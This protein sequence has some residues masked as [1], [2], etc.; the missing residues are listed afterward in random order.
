MGRTLKTIPKVF[1]ADNFW[2]RLMGLMGRK[3]WPRHW[4]AICFPRCNAVHTFFV[5]LKF[6]ILFLDSEKK[7]L[8]IVLNAKSWWFY[9]GPLSGEYCLELPSDFIRKNKLKPGDK[10]DW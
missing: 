7:I 8:K 2:P 5:F 10:V 4:G 3:N 1:I 9:F 6:D